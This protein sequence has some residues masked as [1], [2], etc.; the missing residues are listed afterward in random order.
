MKI[1]RGMRWA[2]LAV[3]ATVTGGFLFAQSAVTRLGVSENMAHEIILSTMDGGYGYYGAAAKSFLALGPGARAMA[4][5]ETVSWAKMYVNSP[6]FKQEW[7]KKRENAKPQP[8]AAAGSV[9]DALKQQDAQMQ[10]QIA[11]MQKAAA[12]LPP[13]QR[14]AMEDA[15]K[16]I[17]TQ[18]QAA[19]KNPSQQNLQ[20]Q[21]IAGKQAS[22]QAQYQDALKKWQQDFPVDPSPAIARR[23]KEF[24][25]MSAT[26]NF[27]AKTVQRG[28]SK[29]FADEQYEHKPE[30]WKVCYRAGR[31]ATAAARA[32]ATAWLKELGQ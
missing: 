32:A 15:I 12:S 18:L 9:D 14:K 11:D 16:Q 27:D 23:L 28:G 13:D 4:V 25:S 29:Y 22:D 6:A 8:P 24:L 21:A 30:D 3:A 31:E 5:N 26:V 20:R 19:S 17:T 10:K 7:A 1:S 2:A